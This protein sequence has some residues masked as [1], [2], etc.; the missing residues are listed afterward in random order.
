VSGCCV[1]V[2]LVIRV[3]CPGVGPGVCAA[4]E[5]KKHHVALSAD[6]MTYTFRSTTVCECRRV[7]RI[8]LLLVILLKF[9]SSSN[10]WVTIHSAGDVLESAS[11]PTLSPAYGS[12]SWLAGW[13]VELIGSLSRKKSRLRQWYV[14]VDTEQNHVLSTMSE[15]S[16]IRTIGHSTHIVT[17]PSS[18]PLRLSSV[19]GVSW[20]G[21]RP[22][23]HKLDPALRFLIGDV[24]DA[25]VKDSGGAAN[26]SH[27]D[28][29]LHRTH[30]RRVM[31]AEDLPEESRV[32]IIHTLVVVLALPAIKQ[33][34][35]LENAARVARAWSRRFSRRGW[36]ADAMAASGEKIVVHLDYSRGRRD[37]AGSLLSL[38]ANWL[39]GQP[40][41]LWLEPRI[42]HE[43]AA[44]YVSK[45]LTFGRGTAGDLTGAAVPP[46]PA[47]G[48]GLEQ[49]YTP[50]AAA[51]AAVEKALTFPIN[52]GSWAVNS[53]AGSVNSGDF[54]VYLP[55]AAPG[56][57]GGGMVRGAAGVTPDFLSRAASGTVATASR[58]TANV[59]LTPAAG[60]TLSP[61]DGAYDGMAASFCAIPGDC[62]LPDAANFTIIRYLA[63][64]PAT[65]V[66]DPV[67]PAAG[68]AG[69]SP[70]AGQRFAIRP[71]LQAGDT[72]TV[73]AFADAW[74]ASYTP[75]ALSEAAA[76]ISRPAASSFN[77]PRCSAAG[78]GPTPPYA[79][80]PALLWGLGYRRLRY[81]CQPDAAVTASI[82]LPVPAGVSAAACG[83]YCTGAL[84]SPLAPAPLSVLWARAGLCGPAN[85]SAGQAAGWQ[86][87]Q[88][89]CSLQQVRVGAEIEICV[90]APYTL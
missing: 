88:C 36:D 65:V 16:L 27:G 86:L 8:F 63:G 34:N 80:L 7:L 1:M 9:T 21:K 70:G 33:G 25:S 68:A 71:A 49:I 81:T 56:S 6:K 24:G 78:A 48:G 69:R 87:G 73:H 26:V 4:D 44:R 5:E 41:V 19:R 79:G 37:G 28:H 89:R 46:S 83:A 62:F 75:D 39:A 32:G 31:F 18:T 29:S 15:V 60:V 38:V 52:T 76:A 50:S 85:I 13:V 2:I 14:V 58:S 30:W 10:R 43:P 59:T 20:V 72:V 40:E 67:W 17:G 22:D 55:R 35:D 45:L 66:L 12:V 42:A 51:R 90:S 57:I 47:A 61:D 54:C 64:P 84:L 3:T 53:Q 11:I 77:L 82:A 23:T 74:S